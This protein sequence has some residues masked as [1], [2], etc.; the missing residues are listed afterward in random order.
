MYVILYIYMLIIEYYRIYMILYW[1]I[2][3]WLIVFA[4]AVHFI[5]LS[6][7]EYI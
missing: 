3:Q 1:Y 5:G 7:N 2:R 4:C 6:I